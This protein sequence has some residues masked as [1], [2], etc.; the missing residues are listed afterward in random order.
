MIAM[1]YIFFSYLECKLIHHYVIL[2]I[3]QINS[4]LMKTI[5]FKNVSVFIILFCFLLLGNF[6]TDNNKKM[7]CAV[8]NIQ[9]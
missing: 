4:V 2:L 8:I 3:Q 6:N 1:K 5:I 7:W 9:M